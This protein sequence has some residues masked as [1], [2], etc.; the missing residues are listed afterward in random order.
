MKPNGTRLDFGHKGFK[1]EEAFANAW[2][3]TEENIIAQ[4]HNREWTIAYPDPLKAAVRTGDTYKDNY[5]NVKYDKKTSNELNVIVDKI[6]FELVG[7]EQ[8][9]LEWFSHATFDEGQSNEQ[10][11]LDFTH[12]TYR[13]RSSDDVFGGTLMGAEDRWRWC[14]HKYSEDYDPDDPTKN[15]PE[16]VTQTDAP[17]RCRFC[18]ELGLIRINH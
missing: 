11:I 12:Y 16:Y 3:N 4:C 18:K 2:K 13:Y 14:G 10:V 17:C 15:G 5:A 7:Y 6:G 1:S 9:W 8:F